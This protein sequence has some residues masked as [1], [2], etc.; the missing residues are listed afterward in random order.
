MQQPGR[1]HFARR[2]PA[3][4]WGWVQK[5]SF[6]R[7]WSCCIS[8]LR[9]SRMQ[10]HGSKYFVRR[11][12]PPPPTLGGFNRSKFSFSE[13]GHAYQI[14]WN[15]ESSNLVATS[16]PA[17]PLTTDPQGQIST[18]SEHG[19]VACHIFKRESRMQQHGI[20]YFARRH[21][22]DPRGGVIRSKF[23]F[24]RT[25]S[26]CISTERERNIEHHACTYSLPTHILNLSVGLN[27][28]KQI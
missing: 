17:D 8:N 16:L 2:P 15:H 7:T 18:F 19:H 1:K 27:H 23:N 10:Q 13:H 5:V 28:I 14:E 25:Q 21:P 24:F 11:P 6:F 22:S 4:P 20:K 9:H 3:R 12:L 26:Y